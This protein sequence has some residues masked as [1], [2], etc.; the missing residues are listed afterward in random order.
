MCALGTGPTAAS[1]LP[2]LRELLA[3]L[4]LSSGAPDPLFQLRLNE[5]FAALA[6]RD[7]T[8][9]APWQGLRQ[10][11]VAEL[12][13][14]EGQGPP[15]DDVT[16]ARAVLALAYDQVLPGY[17]E[18]HVDLLFHQTA[19]FLFQPFFQ[20]RVF[21]AVLSARPPSEP[22]EALAAD[23]VAGLNDFVGH[24]PVAA[25]ESAERVTPYAHERVR[26]VPIFL[27]GAGV[28]WGPY[29]ELLGQALELLEQAPPELL[30]QSYFDWE[31]LEEIAVDPRAYDFEHPVNKRPNYHFGQWDPG[32]LNRQGC[33]SR[34]VL[35][36]VTLDVLNSRVDET[37]A[38]RRKGALW[39]AAAVLSG[40]MLM[41]STM[42]G[43]APETHD[44]TVS[45]N[46]LLPRIAAQRDAY[47][48]QLLARARGAHGQALRE[49]AARLRQP[50][51]GARQHL[52]HGLARLRARQQQH[53][54]LARLFARMGYPEASLRQAAVVPA[55]SARMTAE[56]DCRV[57][58]SH[59]AAA[60]G[61]LPEAAALLPPVQDLLR[62]AI[63]CGALV[64]P[65]TILGFQ[66]QFSIFTALENSV[67]DH[68]VEELV[69]LV[70]RIL[71]LHAR[72]LRQAAAAGDEGLGLRIE[73]LM[74]SLATWWDQFATTE[75]G[76]VRRLS[77]G[78]MLESASRVAQ[79]LGAW[80]RGG[81][82]AGDVAFWREHVTEFAS[83]KSYALVVSALV[84]QH[85]FVAALALLIE[86]LSRAD[87]ILLADNGHSWHGLALRWVREVISAPAERLGP[88]AVADPAAARWK[89]LR[90][91]LDFVEANA[92]AYWQVPS[93][94]ELRGADPPPGRRPP[95]PRGEAPPA[96]ESLLDDL[97]FADESAE[98]EPD[99]ELDDE[100]DEDEGGQLYRAA[101]EDMTYRD[102]S[103]DGNEGSLVDSGRSPAPDDL[104]EYE[105]ERLTPHLG[106]LTTVALLWKSIAAATLADERA[107]V[108]GAVLDERRATLAEWQAQAAG[109]AASWLRLL[110]AVHQQPVAKPLGTRESLADYDRRRSAKQTLVERIVAGSSETLEA[111][112]FLAAAAGGDSASG[113]A[114]GCAPADVGLL[115]A[116][117]RG[118][119]DELRQQ[120]PHW[121]AALRRE[122]LLYLPLARGGDPEVIA[123]IQ[124]RQQLMRELAVGL[125]RWGLMNETR[126]LLLAVQQAERD[127]PAGE[128]AVTE[129]DR[130]FHLAYR[131][132]VECLVESAAHWDQ[133]TAISEHGWRASDDELVSQL[134]IISES[135]LTRWL[136]HSR[137]LRLSALERVAGSE[138]WQALVGFIERYGRD[139]FG[140]R[141]F[142]P[143][144]LRA[145]LDQGSGP[146]LDEL[147]LH[148]PDEPPRLLDELDGAISRGEAARHLELIATAI[149]ENYSEYRDYNSTTTQSDRG[150]L[151]Y[152]FLDFLR[153][154]ARYER[155]N[156]N[157]KPVALAHQV[158]ERKGRSAA[159]EHWRRIVAERT[160]EA[161]D[162]H[163]ARLEELSRKYGM[164]LPTIADRLAERFVRPMRL[165]RIRALVRPAI[166]EKRDDRPL[167]AG[168]LLEQEIADF[169][170]EPT[171]AGLDLP[172]WLVALELEAEQVL[173]PAE[174]AFDVPE[175]AAAI[176][177]FLLSTDEVQAQLDTW[178]VEADD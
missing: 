164:R 161:A 1:G 86:W 137:S 83:P 62:R 101:Y 39:E 128:G 43:R 72:L 47:Y 115:A 177:Q 123:A 125:P 5:L 153:L 35:V 111:S 132:L 40:T 133:G 149:L 29:R 27:R 98:G 56:I 120:L 152:T 140:P 104:W 52:N 109:R 172:A 88:A 13:R 171:G 24:R 117:F 139:L 48:E 97:E 23:I 146:W 91:F 173:A 78:E 95:P 178:P 122:R 66:G 166:E 93:F 54:H 33:F 108:G 73:R 51:G 44:S 36:Q 89:L 112:R 150:E 81:A 114:P 49:E 68:R 110:R 162:W 2:H 46:T 18:H 169:S 103:A 135:L 167:Q 69:Q 38:R 107:S 119:R 21:E 99:D 155:V 74:A 42:G 151:L 136:E 41:A 156:W 138:K 28:G 106:V 134:Q 67:R 63:E 70:E 145:L 31:R 12:N 80:H 10:V 130:L 25:L 45:L 37:P 121:L 92:E 26:P 90:R 14:L 148:P 131:G 168:P 79:A 175:A 77:G 96:P 59:H 34:F 170:R 143:G 4:N 85:D 165:D 159:A 57:S 176:P 144:N 58:A 124:G 118:R 158:L 174:S 160:S 9:E 100:L 19:E 105:L 127:N 22:S 16:Q 76:G 6:V 50:L 82:A 142:N 20:A 157:L 53:V 15:F 113:G 147:A 55:A 84:D 7:G 61:H 60:R 94:P 163:A 116:L 17:L 126:E 129:F 141:F 11:L 3:Y 75:V 64:D 32:H 30:E 71:S 8:D 87:E 65:W 102:S 154:K